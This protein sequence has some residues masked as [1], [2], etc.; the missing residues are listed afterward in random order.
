MVNGNPA[1]SIC[2]ITKNEEK[3]LEN[4]LAAI[5]SFI[6]LQKDAELVV[7]D[8]GSTDKSV[9][10]AKRHGAKVFHFEWIGDFAAAKNFACEKA[11]CDRIFLLDTDEYLE[12]FSNE[13]IEK[14][15]SGGEGNIGLFLRKNHFVTDG[16]GRIANEWVPRIFSRKLYHYEG[17]VHEQLVGA[18]GSSDDAPRIKTAIVADHDGYMLSP[19]D[20]RKKA[21][22]NIELLIKENESLQKKQAS[23]NER[24]YV[25]YQLGKG[26]YYKGD[27]KAAADYFD[28]GLSYDLNEK[29]DYVADMV[30]SYGYALIN[31]GREQEAL[32]L[33][34]VFDTFSYDA[35]YLFVM[36]LIYMKNARFDE[37]ISSFTKATERPE[38]RVEGTNGHLALHNI[39]VILECT[40]REDEA[41]EYYRRSRE[42]NKP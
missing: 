40:G 1:F 10:V 23:D 29:L 41:Q 5:E 4:C 3:K 9:E 6:D 21:D 2:I 36:G 13:D 37:A 26:Y 25:L 38:C 24:A 31:S 16:Q 8:T 19:D 22:R 32:K 20:I 12:A 17:R 39:G 18:N 35:D 34:G 33:E 30:V 27:Y 42:K 11:S 7:V 15:F 14:V 28:E